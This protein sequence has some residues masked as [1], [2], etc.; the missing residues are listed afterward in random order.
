MHRGREEMSPAIAIGAV[1]AV[2]VLPP[3]AVEGRALVHGER[4]E[5]GGLPHEGE[6]AL[7]CVMWWTCGLVGVCV[8]SSGF[9]SRSDRSMI[10]CMQQGTGPKPAT[11]FINCLCM[12]KHIQKVPHEPT[13]PRCGR[14]RTCSAS[15]AG[16]GQAR[17]WRRRRGRSRASAGTWPRS[18]DIG[19]LERG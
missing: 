5:D 10:T 6:H 12:N 2:G 16:G 11:K 14:R 13:H 7:A 17:R 3:G 15:R 19:G 1:G 18:W 9:S 8:G 4:A